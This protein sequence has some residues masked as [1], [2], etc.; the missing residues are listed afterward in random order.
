MAPN[1]VVIVADDTTNSYH[2]C[3]GGPTPTPNID[4]IAADGA[5]FERGYC[6]SSLCCP[7]RWNLFTGQYTGRSRWVYED[8]PEDQPYNV[9]Q[10]G[11]LDPET[12]T[13]AKTLREAG[14]FTG[15]IGKWH[16]RFD[17]PDFP[18][19]EPIHIEGDPDD[20][21]VDAEIRRRQKNA[22][23]VVK[24]CGGFE[25]AACVHWGNIAGY[26]HPKL[27]VHNPMWKTDGA[28]EFLDSA[29]ED[30]RPFYL[31]LANTVPHGP[32]PHK[33]LGADHSYTW[34][35]K[36]DEA[37]GS[38]PPD[39]TVFERMR[40]AGIQTD[41]PIAGVNA[42]M[43]ML[44]DQVGAVLEK[45]D[46]MGVA[47]DTIVIYTAD[48]GVPGKGSAHV[49]G[50]HLPFVM[51]W[52]GGMPGGQ[53]VH[54]VFSWVDTVP[55]LCDAAGTRMPED[56]CIDG[57]SVLGAL[58]GQE[59]WPRQVAYH[60][61]GWSRSVIKGRYHYIATRYPE[62]AI[63]EFK[64][65]DPEILP[66]IGQ[67]FDRLNA[68]FIPDYFEPDQ[69]YDLATDPFERHN[70]VDDPTRADVLEDLREELWAIADT[71]PRPFPREPHPFRQTERYQQLKAER[72]AE[73]DAIEHYPPNCYV[74][75]VWFANLHDPGVED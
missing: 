13:L 9:S 5:R 63:E 38:H 35:G 1:I 62:K 6:C 47:D 66:G 56:A 19:D 28:L 65:D 32:D 22:Q 74:P 4:R 24:K 29:A 33:S 16:S 41:G 21:E 34:S 44:D 25:H 10:N 69:L 51:R 18:F 57:V 52:P 71:M 27:R 49:T 31:H 7:S 73:V 37:P 43:I 11:M 72:R 20:P 68:P 59:K 64:K 36:L 54:D 48:H 75:R 50:Q 61:M 60:E 30:D 40:E 23:E 55:T 39:E 14:Y 2:S 8:V 15:H 12:P 53:V 42:G 26:A 67:P 70:L 45:L 3:Y 58:Q 46:E 17:I